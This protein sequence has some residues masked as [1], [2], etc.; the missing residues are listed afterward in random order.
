[1]L[2]VSKPLVCQVHTEAIGQLRRLL[3]D[4]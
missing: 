2:Q 4:A 1:M 3:P